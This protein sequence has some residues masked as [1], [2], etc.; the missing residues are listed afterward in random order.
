MARRE[1]ARPRTVWST[2]GATDPPGAPRDEGVLLEGDTRIGMTIET[3]I[4]VTGI[5]RGREAGTEGGIAAET[6]RILGRGVIRAETNEGH[7]VTEAVAI[8]ATRLAILITAVTAEAIDAVA[9]TGRPRALAAG[10]GRGLAAAIAVAGGGGAPARMPL[11]E[12]KHATVERIVKGQEAMIVQ[13]TSPRLIYQ[14]SMSVKR[15]LTNCS[16]V[17][18]RKVNPQSRVGVHVMLKSLP[19]KL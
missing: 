9:G 6:G 16:T 3:E 12:V 18:L 1:G 17:C 11:T 15:M 8:A 4:E 2:V 19:V 7:T 10:T 14:R 13:M 5:V